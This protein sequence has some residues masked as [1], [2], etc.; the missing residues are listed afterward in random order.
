MA[1][2]AGQADVEKAALLGDLLVVDGLPDRQRS[3][4]ESRQQDGVPLEAL[5]PVQREQVDAV[6]RALGLGRRPRLERR[7]ASAGIESP[8]EPSACAAATAS[9]AISSTSASDA[10]RSRASAPAA[11]PSGS[12]PELRPQARLQ[13]VRPPPARAPSP[14]PGAGAAVPRAPRAARRTAGR[15]RG[16]GCRPSSAPPR[17]AGPGRSSGRGPR[18]RPAARPSPTSRRMVATQEVELGLAVGAAPDRRPR[19][20][21]LRRHEA[22]RSPL[23]REEAVGE[24]EDLRAAAVVAV[25]GD[26]AGAR[27]RAPRSRRGTP[28]SAPAKV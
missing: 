1:A 16:T 7:R 5:G 6:G 15:G 24:R 3:L 4:L 21:W 23:R 20:R 28:T 9:R 10:V 18:S 14:A 26:L 22:L 17:A 19:S 2:G 8:A 13:G 27:E 25:E 11:S 12:K